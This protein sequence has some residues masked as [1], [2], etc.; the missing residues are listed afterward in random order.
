MLFMC[1]ILLLYRFD[2]DHNN[3]VSDMLVNQIT[4]A[5]KYTNEHTVSGRY[6]ILIWF[7]GH[8]IVYTL[9]LL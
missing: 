5:G 1:L 7:Y 6:M 8:V 9:Q 2:S 3:L 4:I